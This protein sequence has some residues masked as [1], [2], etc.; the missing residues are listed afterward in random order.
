[1]VRTVVGLELLLGHRLSF[2]YAVHAPPVVMQSLCLGNG[3]QDQT[4]LCHGRIYNN[5]QNEEEQYAK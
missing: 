5:A 4:T 3:E 1:M 2:G